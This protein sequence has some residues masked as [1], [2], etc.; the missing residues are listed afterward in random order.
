LIRLELRCTPRSGHADLAW[1]AGMTTSLSE[2]CE[3]LLRFEVAAAVAQLAPLPRA[4]AVAQSSP[5]IRMRDGP[6]F[7]EL[8]VR[9]GKS[10]VPPQALVVL[11]LLVKNG[12]EVAA[13]PGHVRKAWYDVNSEAAKARQAYLRLTSGS[14]IEV[15]SQQPDISKLR[16]RHR[17]RSKRHELPP[18]VSKVPPLSN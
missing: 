16:D 1:L 18:G 9:V 17:K 12:P 3:F 2:V 14:V 7:I 6:T 5:L 10:A 15:V 4:D 11:A 8:G 13:W